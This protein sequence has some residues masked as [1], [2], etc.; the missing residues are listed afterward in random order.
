MEGYLH[1][2]ETCGTVDGPGIR[3]VVFMQGCPLRCQYCHNPDTWAPHTG[4]PTT[5]EELMADIVKYRSYMK[6]SGGGVTVSGGEPLLQPKFVAALFEACHKADI[7]TALDT[8]GHCPL[9]LAAPVLQQSDLVLL[10]F[11]AFRPETFRKVTGTGIDQTVEMA[12]YLNEHK[13]PMWIRVVQVPGLTDDAAE[14][15]EMAE[16]LAG[17]SNIERVEISPFH[18]MGEYKWQ[19]LDLPY[20][21]TDTPPATRGQVE[22]TKEL[23]RRAGHFVP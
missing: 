1:S 2:V 14:L 22:R 20:T 21:L 18:K 8:S 12:K 15:G 10:D 6:A 3:Y 13:I 7:H 11:K 19:A 9:S 23:F 5:V 4:K 17:F 16:F